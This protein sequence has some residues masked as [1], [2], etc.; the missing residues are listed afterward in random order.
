MQ[1]LIDINTCTKFLTHLKSVNSYLRN[2]IQYVE[3]R[4]LKAK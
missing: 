1:V 2:I 4:R 3:T